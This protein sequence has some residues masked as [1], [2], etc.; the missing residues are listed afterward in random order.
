MLP[1]LENGTYKTLNEV[2]VWE[3]SP[4]LKSRPLYTKF[5]RAPSRKLFTRLFKANALDLILDFALTYVSVVFNYAGPFFL[6]HILDALVESN[7][8]PQ[9]HA[10]AYVYAFLAFL[11]TLC[12]AQADVQH[13]WYGRRA[14]TRIRTELMSAIYDK[15]L[16]RKDFSGIVDKDAKTAKPPGAKA[17][18]KADEPK[19]GADIGKIVNLMAGDANRCGMTVSAM[20][21]IYG[22][23][24]APQ[25]LRP[26]C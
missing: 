2:D 16:K 11:S 1:L 15:A 7:K 6:K 22:G 4:S 13:L 10:I 26:I 12:K 19:A 24:S 23:V 17:D 9:K 14:S 21:F 20:Y 18:P 5:S 25:N 3:L 8:N